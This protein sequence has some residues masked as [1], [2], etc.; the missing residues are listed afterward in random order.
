MHID[1]GWGMTREVQIE[2]LGS[3]RQ[4][5]NQL[6]VVRYDRMAEALGGHG[7]LVERLEELDGALER[8]VESGRPA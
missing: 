8:A 2:F 7:E 3:D 6:A 5:G 4:I 1:G